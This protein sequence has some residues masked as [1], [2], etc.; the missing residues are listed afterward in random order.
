MPSMV[1]RSLVANHQR[2]VSR[3][4][5]AV[6]FLS[7]SGVSYAGSN[8]MESNDQLVAVDCAFK[9]RCAFSKP[10]DMRGQKVGKG[11]RVK[12]KVRASARPLYCANER[13]VPNWL[14]NL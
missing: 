13:G 6:Y 5:A 1:H 4:Y 3:L 9:A 7:R 12:M 11:Q 14:V 10:C 8:E 2:F